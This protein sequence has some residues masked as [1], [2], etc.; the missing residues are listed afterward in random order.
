MDKKDIDYGLNDIERAK[1]HAKR[2][3]W[4]HLSILTPHHL[5]VWLQSTQEPSFESK[6]L[7]LWKILREHVDFQIWQDI[8]YEFPG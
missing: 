5:Q 3:L 2:L 7:E 8:L 1:F 4:I 6:N